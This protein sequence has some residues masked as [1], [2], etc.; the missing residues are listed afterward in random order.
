MPNIHPFHTWHIVISGFMQHRGTPNGM[1]GLWRDLHQRHA[2]PGVVVE[3]MCWNDKFKKQAEKIWRSSD[4]GQIICIYAY[5][6]GA[7]HG[8]MKLARA[9]EKYK[10]GVRVMVLSDPVFRP[11]LRLLSPLAMTRFPW[12]RLPKKISEVFW[13]FQRKNRPHGH[14]L[15]A[16]DSIVT[17]IHDGVQINYFHQGMDDAIEFHEACHLVANS[18]TMPDSTA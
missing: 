7:G 6:W 8:A 11:W 12:I 3:Y 16:V 17:E 4:V 5:S 1:V 10:L 13:F 15:V 9:L 18:V 14:R 2:G